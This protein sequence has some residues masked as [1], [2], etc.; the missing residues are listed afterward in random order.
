MPANVRSLVTPTNLSD[1]TRLISEY[2][3]EITLFACY[4][5]DRDQYDYYN[6]MQGYNIPLDVGEY[7]PNNKTHFVGEEYIPYYDETE[8]D[9][10]NKSLIKHHGK[11]Y[12]PKQAVP[13]IRCDTRF[14]DFLVC[15]DF[16]RAVEH[17]LV[18]VN[19]PGEHL[20]TSEGDI[21]GYNYAYTSPIRDAD[22]LSI[23]L[24]RDGVY[25]CQTKF[26]NEDH[27]FIVVVNDTKM[28]I[29]NRYSGKFYVKEHD[30]ANG[31][32]NLLVLERNRGDNRP[33]I[34]S[35]FG[36]NPHFDYRY[37]ILALIQ[38]DYWARGFTADEL[39]DFF[40]SIST[41]AFENRDE[42]RELAKIVEELRNT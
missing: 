17:L 39:A 35:I 13:N 20:S 37:M 10:A 36:F 15:Y 22:R 38:C 40:A 16:T 28:T 11:F 26:D 33:L 21:A 19:G 23:L 14:L 5:L 31:L 24:N 8:E 41:A 29:L 3:K 32:G 18:F 1:T 4:G 27:G 12:V 25:I 7:D 34:R 6:T 2:H 9:L 30:L 42:E